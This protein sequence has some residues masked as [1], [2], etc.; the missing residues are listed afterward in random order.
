MEDVVARREARV[1][2]A[3]RREHALIEHSRESTAVDLEP[4]V[5]EPSQ[6]VHERPAVGGCALRRALGFVRVRDL[7]AASE[8]TVAQPLRGPVAET[9]AERSA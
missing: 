5:V 1:E 8:P 7:N 9:R 6:A 3:L 4:T 2:L